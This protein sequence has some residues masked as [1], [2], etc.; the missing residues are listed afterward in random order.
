MVEMT[1]TGGTLYRKLEVAALELFRRTWP[2]I[3]AGNATRRPQDAE[4]GSSHRT[5]DVR[6]ID[7]LDLGRMY[8]A[9]DLINILRARTFPPYPGAYFLHNGKKIYLR[10]TSGGAGLWRRAG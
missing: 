5:A 9:E 8:R 3:N 10:L 1:D 6:A 4:S 7:E 2:S